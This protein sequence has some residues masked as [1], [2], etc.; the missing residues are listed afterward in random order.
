M[1]LHDGSRTMKRRADLA[2]NICH[3]AGSLTRLIDE[4]VKR[5]LVTRAIAAKPTAG[6]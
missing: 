1:V 5:G 6:W 3:D 4:M 2:H